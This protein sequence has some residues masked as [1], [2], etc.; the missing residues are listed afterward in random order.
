MKT[1]YVAGAAV[2]ALLF[3]TAPHLPAADSPGL[4]FAFTPANFRYA[5]V[6]RDPGVAAGPSASAATGVSRPFGA[7]ASSRRAQQDDVSQRLVHR[8][9]DRDLE[10]MGLYRPGYRFWRHV[11][12][13][14]D[15]RMVFGSAYDGSL[16][17]TL[18]TANSRATAM[19]LSKVA[20]PVIY[21]ATRGTFIAEGTERYGSFLNEWGTIF[22][23]FGVPAEVGLAQA[24]VESGLKG[25]VRSEAEAIGF[26]QWLPGNWAR[27]QELSPHVIEAYNQTTQVPYCAAHLAI[28]ATKYGSL[29]PALSEHHAGGI[30]VGRTIIN[31]DYAGGGDVRDRYFLG[32]ELTLVVR[33]TREPGYREVA[34]SYGPRSFRYAEMVFGNI[35]T[36]AAL[37]TE[38]PQE[39]IFAMRP[40][41]PVALDEVANRTGLSIDE[42]R[43]FNPALINR[44]PASANLYLPSHVEDF[45][46]DTA[47]WHRPPAP[48]YMNVLSDFQRIDASFDADSWQ[49][50]SVFDTLRR[51]ES[52]FRAT[53]TAEG[54]VMATVI[55]FVLDEF[56]D[57][58][59]QEILTRARSSERARSV[60][61]QGVRQRQTLLP[62]ADNSS[63][64]WAQRNAL[65]TTSLGFR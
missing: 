18:P 36:I 42:I 61:E 40:E 21:N 63:T 35:G 14:P 65:V 3:G 4:K 19:R 2:L 27:L 20:G 45:G 31:G 30:N 59:Q 51:F 24:L 32:A 29:I 15:G 50:G 46:A 11:F 56:S 17:A 48:D 10:A 52:R 1:A 25:R 58:R 60:R 44:V 23:R 22:E 54:A 37:K 33:Q 28:L 43:R 55:A 6:A 16:L 49:D 5:D 7:G 34:G 26:C 8:Y 53:D 57:G 47:F 12:T 13:I 62:A 64:G 38:F 41:R 9:F 39:R